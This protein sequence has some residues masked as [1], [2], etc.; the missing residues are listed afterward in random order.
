MA[1]S[2]PDNNIV[3]NG[4]PAPPPIPQIVEAQPSS[5]P[6]SEP[7]QTR[8][9]QDVVVEVSTVARVRALRDQGLTVTEIAKFLSLDVKTIDKYLAITPMNLENLPGDGQAV[10]PGYAVQT[11]A[12]K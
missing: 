1:I 2:I 11:P 3:V 4:S 9:P 12:V 6:S 5:A 8:R 7:S 10:Q